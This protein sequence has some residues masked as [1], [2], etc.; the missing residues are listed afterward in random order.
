MKTKRILLLSA[1]V[2]FS[3]AIGGNAQAQQ[4]ADE[5]LNTDNTPATQQLN[6]PT[7]EAAEEPV[8]LPTGEPTVEDMEL[9]VKLNNPD[10]NITQVGSLFFTPRE[11]SLLADARRGFI[12]R[13]PGVGEIEQA[14]QDDGTNDIVKGPRELAL[15]GIVFVA[16]DDWVIWLNGQRIT[17]NAI[18]P[19]IL[20]IKVSKNFIKFQWFD[21]YTNQIFPI[22]LKPHQ[23]FNIDTRIFLPGEASDS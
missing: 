8:Q 11:Q 10:I 1:L 20:D 21:E 23:R 14:N 18:P 3:F 19:E 16:S 22:K 13:P 7:E 4:A 15:G 6:A 9:R 5:N 12:T 2:A 17:M